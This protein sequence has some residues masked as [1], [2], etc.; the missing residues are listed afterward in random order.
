MNELDRLRK[1][2]LDEYQHAQVIDRLDKQRLLEEYQ[3]AQAIDRLDQQN[4]NL[5]LLGSVLADA[6]SNVGLIQADIARLLAV[7]DQALPVIVDHLTLVTSR[8]TEI[9]ELLASP[10]ETEAW[11]IFRSGFRA[12]TSATEMLQ[13][14]SQDLA[15]DWFDE[16]INDLSRAVEIYR[17]I[18]VFWFYLGLAH[19]CRGPSEESAEAFSRCSRY[20]VS[21]SPRLAAQSIL[22]SAEQFRGIGQTPKARDILHKFLPPLE[23]C[24]EIHLNLAKYHAESQQLTRAFELAPLLASVARAEGVAGVEHAAAGVCRSHDGPVS[25]ILAMEEALHALAAAAREVDLDCA[26][27]VPP[28]VLLPDFGVDA[29]LMAE[30]N[31]PLMAKQAHEFVNEVKVELGQLAVRA[32]DRR[33][34]YEQL[35]EDG[36]SRAE[37]ARQI[38]TRAIELARDKSDAAVVSARREEDSARAAYEAAQHELQRRESALADAQRIWGAYERVYD[39]RGQI[40]PMVRAE[41]RRAAMNP[42]VL[43]SGPEAEDVSYLYEWLKSWLGRNYEDIMAYES[44]YIGTPYGGREAP[45]LARLGRWLAPGDWRINRIRVPDTPEQATKAVEEASAQLEAARKSLIACTERVAQ[46]KQRRAGEE[47]RKILQNSVDMASHARERFLRQVEED[48]QYAHAE[49]VSAHD[50]FRLASEATTDLIRTVE[51]AI[52]SSMSSRDRIVPSS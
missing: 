31:I 23:R 27:K 3:R 41:L 24:A 30:V 11:E 40:R 19:A 43:G 18:A 16:A 36:A 32:Q 10:K 1:V 2:Q 37:E 21:G 4:M 28:V 12:L 26:E 48:I 29:L 5:S 38:A 47:A 34:R 51:A 42:A 7:T 44:R 22:L 13:N 15:D 25:R 33:H 35:R 50:A 6:N 9:E 39:E 52:K 17:N 49:S 8:L 14:G 46:A 45:E 20:A